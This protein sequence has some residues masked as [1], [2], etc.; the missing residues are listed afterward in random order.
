M[1]VIRL[2]RSDLDP[3]NPMWGLP[4]RF[5]P[6]QSRLRSAHS[7]ALHSTRLYRLHDSCGR[8]TASQSAREEI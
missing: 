4:S 2:L 8:D 6:R 7:R 5:G 3:K 1:I